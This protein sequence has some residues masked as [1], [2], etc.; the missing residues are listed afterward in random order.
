[1][2][3]NLPDDLRDSHAVPDDI[4]GEVAR[5]AP[6]LGSIG[7]RLHYVET[8]TST[9][10][11]A[12]RL[13]DLG[14]QEGTTVVAEGQ[15]A[16][17]GRQGRSWFSPPGAGLYVSIVLRPGIVDAGVAGGPSGASVLSL[18]TLASGVAAAEGV[19]TSTGLPV[20]IKWP[21][22]LV[23]GR[24][25]LAGILAE[26]PAN[27]PALQYVVLGIGIN[28]RPAAYPPELADVATSIAAE[29]DRPVDRALVLAETLA[30]LALRYG[31]LRERRFDAILTAWRTLSPLVRSSLVEWDAPGGVMRGRT[32][33]I[34][35]NGALV[36]RVGRRVQRLNAGE[37]R[38]IRA[39][40]ER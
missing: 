6:R 8:A 28:L 17:R 24:R 5:V 21:N 20:E 38:W 32:Q 4:R 30:A 16:G 7:Q 22:D 39:A 35:E 23:I 26:A 19:R 3:W 31:D 2:N 9:N 12:A 34:D 18:L 14:A 1:L 10:D 25:K 29:T 36:V 37:V 33:D 15:T 27:D 11:I 13:A 40:G